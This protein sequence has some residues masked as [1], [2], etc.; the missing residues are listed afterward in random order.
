MTYF[1][2]TSTINLISLGNFHDIDP[3]EWDTDA[4]K[5]HTLVGTQVDYQDLSLVEVTVY[6]KHG[7]NVIKDNDK[8]GTYDKIGYDRDGE[9]AIQKTDSSIKANLEI[10]LTDG[11]TTTIEAVLIQTENGDLFATDLLNGGTLDNLDISSIKIGEITES[12]ASGWFADQSV[13]NTTFG[14]VDNRDGTVEGTAGDDL[15]DV[16]YTG[17]PDGDRIDNNDAIVEGEGPQD[18]IVVAGAGN[19]TVLAGEGN[20]DVFGGEGDDT[21]FGGAGDDIL[22]GEEG[23]DLVVGNGGDDHIFGGTGNDVLY[24]DNLD[25]ATAPQSGTREL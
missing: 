5:A 1:Y 21:L 25:G 11:T 7:D 23:D 22:R 9:H 20:D 19:D 18:D 17:D 15:I 6:D 14:P 10:T 24:G 3:H 16:N 12:K 13:D 4:E 2:K 8:Y